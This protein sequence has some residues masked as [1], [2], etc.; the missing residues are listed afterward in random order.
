MVEKAAKLKSNLTLYLTH[1]PM[2]VASGSCC[3]SGSTSL[4]RAD[5]LPFAIWFAGNYT[6][7]I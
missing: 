4:P 2:Q 7:I 5:S 1:F 6:E 3:K